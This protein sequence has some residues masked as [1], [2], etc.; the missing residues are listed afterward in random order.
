MVRGPV[1]QAVAGVAAGSDCVVVAQATSEAET[2]AVSGQVAHVVRQVVSEVVAAMVCWFVS[3]ATCATKCG[4]TAEAVTAMVSRMKTGRLVSALGGA[5]GACQAGARMSARSAE[6]WRR[7]SLA[8][9]NQTWM[10]LSGASAP[11]TRRPVRSGLTPHSGLTQGKRASPSRAG[12][13][14]GTPADIR[15][16]QAAGLT[17]LT[18]SL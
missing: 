10:E 2:G 18:P 1:A 12:F 8:T 16:H 9:P 11:V 4:T 6:A 17:C 15:G 13:R 5:L 14:P 3:Q 7:S